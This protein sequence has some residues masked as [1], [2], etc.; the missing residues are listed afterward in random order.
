MNLYQRMK[1]Y[2]EDTYR[3]YLTRRT[4]VIIRLDGC[5]FRTLTKYFKKPFDPLFIK[6]MQ[7]T[8]KYLCENIQNCKLGYVQSD[9]ISLVLCDYENLDTESWFGNNL[10]KILSVSAS[11]ATLAF[12]KFFGLNVIHTMYDN[13]I[14]T[15]NLVDADKTDE[16]DFAKM[17]YFKNDKIKDA[18]FDSRA[19]NLPIEEVCNYFICRQ[20]DATRN[21]IQGFGQKYFSHKELHRKSC[22]QIQDML[23]TEKGINWNDIPTTLKRGSCCVK[24]ESSRWKIDNDIPIFTSDRDYIDKR[25]IF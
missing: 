9:E 12:N 22:N 18:T 24:T 25:I 17:A 13:H 2:Y 15:G 11:M 16:Y 7:K 5:H 10:N 14:N 4:P 21:S 3:I 23:M 19:F 6:T 8:T 20:Q 1:R